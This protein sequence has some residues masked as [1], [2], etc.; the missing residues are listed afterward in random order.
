M[1]PQRLKIAVTYL[2]G[3]GLAVF[4]VGLLSFIFSFLGTIFCAAVAGMMLGTTRQARSL[5]VP[6]SVIFPAVIFALL[7]GL[8]SDLPLGQVTEL[9]VVCFG[10]FWLI[11]GLAVGLVACERKGAATPAGVSAERRPVTATKASSLTNAPIRDG[12]EQLDGRWLEEAVTSRLQASKKVLEIKRGQLELNQVERD[13]RVR[14]LFK[15]E[16]RLDP[17]EDAAE[18]VM[19]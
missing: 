1:N 6:T 17:W 3:W 10:A 7:R 11:F 15:G 18:W 8:K 13:G 4:F 16:V 14:L 2:A 9:A 12:L 19:I 5:A